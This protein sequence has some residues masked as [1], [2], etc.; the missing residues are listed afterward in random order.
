MYG[1]KASVLGWLITFIGF[2]LFYFTMLILGWQGM[3]RRYFD[4]L[5]RFAG[6][7]LFTS[8]G[9]FIMVAGLVIIAVNLL[10]GIKHGKK[11]IDNPWEAATLEWS[12]PTPAPY[13]NWE[14]PPLVTR[15]PYDFSAPRASETHEESETDDKGKAR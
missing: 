9:A 8:V 7:Q 12:L 2:N 14:E 4:F 1:K 15:G 10:W 13:E 6:L 11:A 3:P 5:P